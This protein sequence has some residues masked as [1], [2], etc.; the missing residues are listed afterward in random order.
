MTR[1]QILTCRYKGF[2]GCAW[3]DIYPV[4]QDTFLEGQLL[5]CTHTAIFRRVRR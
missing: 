4:V 1:T 3:T 5:N 2:Y